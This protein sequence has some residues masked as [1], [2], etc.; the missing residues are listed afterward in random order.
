MRL[1]K[2]E[3]NRPDRRILP[4]S[5]ST[6]GERA[7]LLKEVI[8]IG[9]AHHKRRPGDY[10]FNPPSN[11]RP[12]KTPCDPKG[13]DPV[14]VAKARALF[15]AGMAKGMFSALGESGLPKYVWAVDANG[16]AFEAKSRPE[17]ETE[18]HGYP[19]GD[20]EAVM[21]SYVLGE[22]KQR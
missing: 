9:S 12:S 4:A 8:Y 21:R 15:G 10:G 2:R 5:A 7:A 17:H 14:L 19:L 11:P 1:R 16:V 20:D 13:K 3:G 6:P 18:Y 22:W